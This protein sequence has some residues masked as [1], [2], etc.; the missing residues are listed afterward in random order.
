MRKKNYKGRC[1]KKTVDKFI[2][3]CRTYDDLQLKTAFMLSDDENVKEIQ[4]NVP[5]DGLDYTTDF[6][7]KS[8]DKELGVRE[9]VYRENLRKPLTLKLL[10][11]SRE[12]WIR[13]GIKDWA[14]VVDMKGV[15]RHEER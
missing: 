12:Y 4:S 5:L 15:K 2:D 10:D 13:R 7:F 14:I 11:M 9:C 6:V 1:N 8:V 3:V